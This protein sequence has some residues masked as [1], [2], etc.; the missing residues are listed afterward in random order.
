MNSLCWFL[1]HYNSHIFQDV[2][3]TDIDYMERQLDFTID[4]EFNDLPQFV[5]KIRSEGM[6]YIIILVSTYILSSFLKFNCI[7]FNWRYFIFYL[8]LIILV[9]FR[10]LFLTREEKVFQNMKYVS[11]NSTP[12]SKAFFL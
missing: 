3:Y 10:F 11:L 9:L 8:S 7:Y 5:D 2:Q 12:K 4:D 1:P 6:R